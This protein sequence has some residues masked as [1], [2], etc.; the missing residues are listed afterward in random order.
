MQNIQ[1]DVFF[2]FSEAINE[3]ERKKEPCEGDGDDGGHESPSI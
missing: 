3:I 2:F 1:N